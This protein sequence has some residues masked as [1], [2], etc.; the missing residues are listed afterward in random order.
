M[1]HGTHLSYIGMKYFRT[2]PFAR[3]LYAAT[4]NRNGNSRWRKKKKMGTE[5]KI[6][7]QRFKFWIS[8]RAGTMWTRPWR[9]QLFTSL[10]PSTVF[11]YICECGVRALGGWLACLCWKL[12]RCLQLNFRI[13]LL[14]FNEVVHMWMGGCVCVWYGMRGRFP[15]EM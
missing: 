4:R 15:S 2:F 12:K 13:T 10:R 1:W 11:G 7:R 9:V 5:S 6:H 3:S 8:V 14:S